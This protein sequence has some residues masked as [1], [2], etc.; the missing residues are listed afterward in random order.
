MS[1]SKAV[2]LGAD[3]IYTTA[4][5]FND[6][7]YTPVKV[8]VTKAID[9]EAM[10]GI[11]GNTMA[12]LQ[13]ESNADRNFDALI[14]AGADWKHLIPYGVSECGIK[15]QHSQ[16]SSALLGK[17]FMISL[18]VDP[19][20]KFSRS[21][22]KSVLLWML[23]QTAGQALGL[24]FETGPDGKKTLKPDADLSLKEAL[25]NEP[26]D[27]KGIMKE[28]GALQGR[29]STKRSRLMKKMS[30]RTTLV[31]AEHGAVEV[32]A[33]LDVREY[34]AKEQAETDKARKVAIAEAEKAKAIADKA[35]LVEDIRENVKGLRTT[36]HTLVNNHEEHAESISLLGKTKI[37]GML[38]DFDSLLASLGQVSKKHFKKVAKK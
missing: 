25:G 37:A 9:A 4:S 22:N 2:Q 13:A 10:H 35:T 27:H 24:N 6:A 14:E 31:D 7:E 23:K 15:S 12:M 34:L 11:V 26:A 33:D 21:K 16:A 30:R 32:I 17:A 8:E 18:L 19:S 3:R 29:A 38:A 20:S 5:N 36:F 28:M 1:K